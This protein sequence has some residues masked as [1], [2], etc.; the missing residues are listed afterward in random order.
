M[1]FIFECNILRADGNYLIVALFLQDVELRRTQEHFTVEELENQT[2]IIS[3]QYT[4]R[5]LADIPKLRDSIVSGEIKRQDAYQVIYEGYYHIFYAYIFR[6]MRTAPMVVDQQQGM[7]EIRDSLRNRGLFFADQG[8][9]L[10]NNAPA[11]GDVDSED[12]D[13]DKAPS[14]PV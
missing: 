12:G 8:A 14:P 4:E 9:A 5:A 1:K 6:F 3:Q 13:Q 2:A 7:A 11:A 10:A